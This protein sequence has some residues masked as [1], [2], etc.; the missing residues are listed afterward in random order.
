N[1]FGT[2]LAG[3]SLWVQRDA[4]GNAS[5]SLLNS[6]GT[7]ETQSGDI[8]INTGTLTNQR[9]GLVVTE[10]ESTA[11]SVPDW[12][13][14]TTVNIPI[15]WFKEGDY[16]IAQWTGNCAT[17]HNAMTPTCSTIYAYAPHKH[18]DIQRV[19]IEYKGVDVVTGGDIGKINSANDL[20]IRSRELNN[21]ASLLYS[22]NNTVLIG[23]VFN[24]SSYQSGVKTEYL[25]YSYTGGNRPN[26]LKSQ[27]YLIDKIKG[28]YISYT[29][30]GTPTYEKTV[31]ESYN[32]LIQAGGTITA[33]FKQD[34]SNTT[35]Q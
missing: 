6:S 2:I 24:N 26:T 19:A 29:L 27:E 22:T 25:T 33:D 28:K 18:A 32:A 17:N 10:S 11:E 35:L 16:G 3:N 20:S 1:V 23:S 7:I 34:I 9:E 4:Q 13:G 12:V 8:T 5:T 21:Q 30:S 15:E 14:K 31:G